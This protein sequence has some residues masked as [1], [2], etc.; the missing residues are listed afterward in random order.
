MKKQEKLDFK[1]EIF[2]VATLFGLCGFALFQFSKIDATPS[3]NNI[4][5]TQKEVEIESYLTGINE[6]L[7]KTLAYTEVE[8]EAAKGVE[9]HLPT[10]TNI[11]I[12]KDA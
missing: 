8:F 7:D 1:K 6:P 4:K 9:F 3:G 10:G 11:R 2:L 12:P 5:S